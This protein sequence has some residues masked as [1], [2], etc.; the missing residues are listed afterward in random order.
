[1][2]RLGAGRHV[3]RVWVAVYNRQSPLRL[4]SNPQTLGSGIAPPTI[5]RGARARVP[6]PSPAPTALLNTLLSLPPP[7]PLSALP[8]SRL[9][10]SLPLLP[11]PPTLLDAMSSARYASAASITAP[12]TPTAL[13]PSAAAAVAATALSRLQASARFTAVGRLGQGRGGGEGRVMSP[14]GGGRRAGR[15]AVHER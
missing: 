15:L 10:L 14:K 4:N 12:H 8:L 7:L 5:P 11:L 13:A 9:S 3:G 1:M 6:C 2:Q